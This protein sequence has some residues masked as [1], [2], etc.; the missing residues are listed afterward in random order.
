MPLKRHKKYPYTRQEFNSI[1][2]K[3]VETSRRSWSGSGYT[4]RWRH[5]LAMERLMENIL[6]QYRK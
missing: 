6:P 2:K 1:V 4:E 5:A 3:R